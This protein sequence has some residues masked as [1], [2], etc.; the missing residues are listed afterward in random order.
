MASSR[1][2]E[3]VGEMLCHP[4]ILVLTMY[5]TGSDQTKNNFTEVDG[6]SGVNL[7]SGLWTLQPTLLISALVG[8]TQSCSSCLEN[9]AALLLV[10]FESLR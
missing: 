2:Q 4:T 7:E 10:L 9:I 5:K 6:A 3:V 1:K 8:A